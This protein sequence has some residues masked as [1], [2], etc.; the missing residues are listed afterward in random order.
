[1]PG[2]VAT[3]LLDTGEEL[4]EEWRV[5][6]AELYPYAGDLF[7]Y[8]GDAQLPSGTEYLAVVSVELADEAL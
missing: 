3:V 5:A 8:L 2:I 4:T 1:M 7:D 6:S